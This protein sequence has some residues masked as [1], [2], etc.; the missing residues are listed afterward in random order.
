MRY[1]WHTGFVAFLIHRV[2]GIILTLYIFLHLYII[3]QLKD[4]EGYKRAMAL[5]GSPLIKL[6]EV[7]LLALVIAHGLN[8]IRL[9]FSDLGV[10]SEYHKR[11]F[12]VGLALGF[13]VF[14]TGAIPFFSGGAH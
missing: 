3:S 10:P 11:L 12:W 2:T 9:T 7:G 14:I 4:P 6:S 1:R 13:I 8:G 5:M